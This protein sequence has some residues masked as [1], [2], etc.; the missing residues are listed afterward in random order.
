MAEGRSDLAEYF[1]TVLSIHKAIFRM[2][3]ISSP[4]FLKIL[5]E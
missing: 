5:W 1:S 3:E 4:T 2:S